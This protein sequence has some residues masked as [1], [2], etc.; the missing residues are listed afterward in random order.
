M[1]RVASRATVYRRMLVG[2]VI[3]VAAIDTSAATEMAAAPPCQE[4]SPQPAYAPLGAPPNV[5]IWKNQSLA[6]F[7]ARAACV[8]WSTPTFQ[9]LIAV[10]GIF[11]NPDGAGDLLTRFGAVSTLMSVRYW[12]TTDQ[13]WRPLVLSATALTR[14]VATQSRAD[15]TS[16]E[17]KNGK[18]LYF[19]Q[20]DSR[21]AGE[22]IYRMRVRE[23]NPGRLVIETENVT[24]VRWLALTL[25]KAGG[26]HSVYFIEERS[27]G[28]WSYYSLTRIAENGWRI[29]GHE[30]SYINRV[31]ALYR[32]IAGIATDLEPPPSR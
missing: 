5:Q 25:L 19:A 30:K 29:A 17:L 15:F 21:G 10:A 14:K 27:P 12:S 31:V 18:D 24:S 2:L 23:D 13:S 3:A 8:G 28:I 22:V 32:H 1:N 9:L 16:A 11:E 6:D 4:S 20:A 7:P 26:L